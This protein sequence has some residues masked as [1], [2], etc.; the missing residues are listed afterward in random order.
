ME[1][2]QISLE[3]RR[4][5]NELDLYEDPHIIQR[6]FNDGRNFDD[7]FATNNV[8]DCTPDYDI[9]DRVRQFSVTGKHP[10]S[11]ERVSWAQT[12]AA[13]RSGRLPYE[14]KQAVRNEQESPKTRMQRP[15]VLPTTN[16]IYGLGKV[17]PPAVVKSG[18]SN[19]GSVP[20]SPLSSKSS[21]AYSSY[22]S[23]G[24]Q[25][26]GHDSSERSSR[27]L[28]G[29]P[30]SP[31]S[32]SFTL[33]SQGR[34]LDSSTTLTPILE[35][36]SHSNN[37]RVM[38]PFSPPPVKILA[39]NRS[40]KVANLT[41]LPAGEQKYYQDLFDNF[42]REY[43]ILSREATPEPLDSAMQK[44]SRFRHDSTQSEPV[45]F[46]IVG[47]SDSRQKRVTS[48]LEEFRRASHY[49]T[50]PTEQRQPRGLR[51]FDEHMH[52]MDRRLKSPPIAPRSDS[53]EK[54]SRTARSPL[55]SP[56]SFRSPTPPEGRKVVEYRDKMYQK[57]SG[58][59]TRQEKHHNQAGMWA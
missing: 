29:G 38:G 27:T 48:L 4:M 8:K 9:A 52:A 6:N 44:N 14:V 54:M 47:A 49:S 36:F 53:I 19:N 32:D 41:S 40:A 22:S 12:E 13:K 23:M 1:A 56:V 51:R 50:S 34:N 18:N 11:K 26:N 45:Y 21:S 37:S 7:I 17:V 24:Q 42:E 10:Y 46:E 35:N 25:T 28:N 57:Q 5:L 58:S 33:K 59:A 43:E 15:T 39:I 2:D 30:L 16:R 55:L 31:S 20:T 3:T